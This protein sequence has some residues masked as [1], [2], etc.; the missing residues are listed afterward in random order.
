MSYCSYVIIC[1]PAKMSTGWGKFSG[2]N[3][4]CTPRCLWGATTPARQTTPEA[5]PH[6]AL[7]ATFPLEG[8]R[9]REDGE[10]QNLPPLRGEGGGPALRPRCAPAPSTGDSDGGTGKRCGSILN[11]FAACVGGDR[12]VVTLPGI[13]YSFFTIPSY[14]SLW[15]ATTPARQSTPRSRVGADTIRPPHLPSP[16]NKAGAADGSARLAFPI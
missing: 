7:R 8:G 11:F 5:H 16:Q 3:M 9:S 2:W 10:P 12:G 15:G 1:A 6:P 4:R 14:F 13:P